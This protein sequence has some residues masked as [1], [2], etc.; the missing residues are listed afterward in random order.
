M[1]WVKTQV[2]EGKTKNVFLLGQ[3]IGA[4]FATY[5]LTNSWNYDG[6]DPQELFKGVILECPF[7][8]L[9]NVVDH[10]AP[11]AAKILR[12]IGFF[13]NL[14]CP[15]I[16]RVGRITLPMLLIHGTHDSLVPIKHSRDLHA[17]ACEAKYKRLI[18]I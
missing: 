4:A 11:L 6:I 12:F 2:D 15:N 3:S 13:D 10:K 7:T 9:E 14:N 16:D 17:A 5:T 1:R 8:T 18:A